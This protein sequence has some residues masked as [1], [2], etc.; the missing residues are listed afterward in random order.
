MKTNELSYLTLH[1]GFYNVVLLKVYEENLASNRNFVKIRLRRLPEMILGIPY[2]ENCLVEIFA[3]IK[4]NL[5]KNI[6]WKWE[7]SWYNMMKSRI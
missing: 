7:D 6:R 1:S 5:L 3:V 2:F 4:N